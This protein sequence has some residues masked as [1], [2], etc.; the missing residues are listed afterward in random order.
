[1]RGKDDDYA[2][3]FLESERSAE[4]FLLRLDTLGRISFTERVRDA[5]NIFAP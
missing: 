1:M 3:H 2:G 5:C 4:N